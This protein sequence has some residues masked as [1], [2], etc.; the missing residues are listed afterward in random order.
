MTSPLIAALKQIVSPGAVISEPDRLLVYESDGLVHHRGQPSAVVLP[1]DTRQAAEV[2][3][4]LHQAGV[5]VVPRGA[6]TGLAGGCVPT[7]G[8]VVLGTA[9]MNRIISLDVPRRRAR[10]QAGVVNSDLSRAAAPYGLRYA[11]DPSSQTAC[12]IGGNVAQNSGGPHCLKYGVTSRYIMGLTVVTPEGEIVELDREHC[13]N[14]LD[15]T[16]LFVGSEGCFGLV[17]EI[18]A[19]LVPDVVGVRT[20]LASFRRMEEAG[21]AVSALMASGLLPAALEIMDRH[22]ITAVEQSI[23]AAGY[24]RD[25]GAVLVVEFDGHEAGLSSETQQARAILSA[26]N[27]LELREARDDEERAALWKGRKKAFGAMGRL[28]P[29]L[30]VQDATVPRSRLPAV[31]AEIDQI[32]ER[33]GLMIAN[34]FHAGDGNLHPNIGYDRRD[35][36]QVKCVEAVSKEIMQL[37]VDHGGTIT[38]EHGV[39]L[40]KRDYMP[41]VHS[42]TSLWL[43]RQVRAV[44]DRAHNWNRGKVL[45]EATSE[46]DGTATNLPDTTSGAPEPDLIYEPADFVITAPAHWTLQELH[47]HTAPHGQWLAVDGPGVEHMTLESLVQQGYQGALALSHGAMRDLVLG[48]TLQLNPQHAVALGG[49]VVKNVAGFDIVRLLVGSRGRLGRLSRVTL[50]LDH[51]PPADRSIVAVADSPMKL[52]ALA[53]AWAA[54]TV[55]LASLELGWHDAKA[56]LV[57][58]VMGQTA[59]VEAAITQLEGVASE[60]ALR[61]D[62]AAPELADAL[63]VEVRSAVETPE[64]AHTFPTQAGFVGRTAEAV[65]LV[66]AGVPAWLRVDQGVLQAA[67]LPPDPSPKSAQVE[68]WNQE[69][70]QVFMQLHTSADSASR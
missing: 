51:R 28:A 50:R 13:A 68:R 2:V 10:L 65:A 43:Q 30:L 4:L 47:E 60:L 39:G 32:A 22:T 14:E 8:S 70:E 40:D 41:L 19:R 37:C 64:A 23:F 56:M 61:A 17:T 20:L 38:G 58:R 1:E 3:R 6:G 9:R 48:C 44:F 49:R 12:T 57:A 66:P 29:D 18:D 34:M 27:A 31:L 52:A 42:P 24:P 7:P 55:D 11:P 35:P 45:P 26:H 62:R 25:A 15:L 46:S 67:Q 36:D 16:G 59:A 33:T 5:P 63:R 53:D 69:I 54:C 21:A